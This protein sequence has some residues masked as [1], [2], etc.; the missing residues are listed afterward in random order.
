MKICFFGVGGVGGY[1]GAI[2]ADKFIQQHEIYFVARGEHKEVICTH[3]LTLKQE[4][5]VPIINVKPTLCTD[6][7]DELPVCDFVFLSVKGYDLAKAAK[8]L[9]AISNENTIIL[10]LLNGVDIYER[11]VAHLSTGKVFPS[12]IYIGSYI[13]LPGVICKNGG[14][15]N[16]IFGKDPKFSGFYPE[17]LLMLLTDAGI[18]FTW[19]DNVETAIWTKYMFIAAYGLV[20]ATYKKTIGEVLDDPEL[21]Q[22]TKA[23]MSEIKQIATEINIHLS[24]DIVETSF[25]KGKLFPYATKTSLQRDVEQKGR[26]NEIDL[27]GGT[28]IRFAEKYNMPIPN[29]K[30]V[31]ENFVR[32]VK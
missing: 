19:D 8:S 22:I 7:I 15:C 9:N 25:L 20:T 32:N 26:I 27:F 18:N 2:L 16:L 31:V 28:L 30:E 11:I 4:V 21:S 24:A 12:C 29:I 3:G 10:P 14:S 23:I 17:S 5:D 6:N 1:I 13:E